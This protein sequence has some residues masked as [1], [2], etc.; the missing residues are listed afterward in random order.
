MMVAPKPSRIAM[1][2]PAASSLLA[3]PSPHR[4]P[5]IPRSKLKG[6]FA[7]SG[8]AMSKPLLAA[9]VISL[10]QRR[11]EDLSLLY[12]G[13]ASYD[14]PEKRCKQTCAFSD[15]GVSVRSLDVANKSV[16][17][18]DMAKAVTA[19]DIILVSGGN[20]LY[21]LDRWEYLGLSNIIRD[22]ALEGKVITG[23]SAGAICW[24]DGGH[25][26]SMDPETSRSFK[27][28]QWEGTAAAGNAGNI[29]TKPSSSSFDEGMWSNDE[30]ETEAETDSESGSD[31][32]SISKKD[33]EYIR[34]NGLG[35]LPGLV[36]PH[37]DRVQSNGIMRSTDF[38]SFMKR[39]SFE[40]GI[41]ID[42]FAALEIDGSKFR[43]LSIPETGL[44]DDED[45]GGQVPPGVWINY[46]EDGIVH[47]KVCPLSG[48]VSDLLQSLKFPE[49]HLVEDERVM[50]CRKANPPLK[51]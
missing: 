50:M 31:E 41:G 24:F 12:I 34:V 42:H 15:M 26:D 10:A 35:I 47:S 51:D 32:D 13:T 5:Y 49:K 33:W 23:G 14:I 6:I 17:P 2:V 40:V 28:N 22:A 1:S 3:T 44:A 8:A 48:H 37:H 45:G 20:T 36:C 46:V 29:T 19:A 11:P 9:S 39:H 18:E 43:V 7:G 27:L 25:S 4:R 38:T 16:L 21:S 30:T